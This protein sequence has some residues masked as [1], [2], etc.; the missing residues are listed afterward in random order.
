MA[1]SVSKERASSL[2][3]IGGEASNEEAE[4][5]EGSGCRLGIDMLGIKG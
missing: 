2:R 4:G 1:R 3:G 5:W